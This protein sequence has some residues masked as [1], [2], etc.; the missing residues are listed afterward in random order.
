[1]VEPDEHAESEAPA[2]SAIRFRVASEDE[3]VMGPAEKTSKSA[4]ARNVAPAAT[5]VTFS[6]TFNVTSVR[7]KRD[8][9]RHAANKNVTFQP[10]WC[11]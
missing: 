6:A 2:A 5:Y 1:M 3:I 7:T 8:P 9:Q 4:M 10:V 11:S